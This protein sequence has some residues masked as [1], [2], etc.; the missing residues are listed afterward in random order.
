MKAFGG[1]PEENAQYTSSK[2]VLVSVPYDGTSTYGKGADKGPDAI[3]DAAENMELYDIETD[4]EPYLNGI[5]LAPV[6][7][8]DKTPEAMVDA[9][10]KSIAKYLEDGKYVSMLGGEHSA[11]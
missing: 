8:E 6:V 3:L 9:V 2:V 4:S 11:Q 1:I 10:E 5:F 7:E